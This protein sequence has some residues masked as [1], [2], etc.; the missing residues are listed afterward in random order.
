MAALGY[1]PTDPEYIAMGLYFGQNAPPVT[2]PQYGWVGCQD[3]TAIAAITVDS[4]SAGT[5]WKLNDTFLILQS[6]ASFG[7]GQ[8]TG[9]SGTTVTSV[10][11]I[12][13]QQGTGYS[14]ANALSTTAQA[15][16]TGTGLEVNITA[17]GE[18]V[19][20]AIT[21]CRLAN[22]SW[23]GAMWCNGA[24]SDVAPIAAYEQTV[25]PAM[26]YI[27]AT[28]SLSALQGT[29]GNVF[30][31]IKAL[32]YGRVQGIYTST[33]NVP[34]PPAPAN[35]YAAAAILGVAMGLNTGAPNSAFT[36]AAKT[37]VGIQT[38]V[39]T[40]AQINV[41]AGTPG[42]GFGNNGNSYNNYANDYDFYY[43]GVNGNG[44]S[45]TTVQ[46]LD[47]LAADAQ[48]SVL[49][50]LQSLP[51]IPQNDAGQALILNA[52]RGACSRA[53]TRGFV[54][55]GVWEGATLLPLTSQSLTPGT[56]L[57][58]GYWV[59]SPSFL[60]QSSGD[61]ALFKSMPVYVAVVLAG[62][63][64]SFVIGIFVQQ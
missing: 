51:S 24:D 12:P 47:M 38:T 53:G 15:P 28:E 37:L 57:P 18:T 50:V 22:T 9:V 26:Q 27:Y 60:T 56:A 14:V 5:G 59:G 48:L 40:Q 52:V 20:Q 39:L 36:V 1:Q 16:S 58:T 11:F 43:Q 49:N 35:V 42:L 10:A 23:Y 34:V 32:N 61:R 3:P 64:Q 46:G 63:Q 31:A 19:L 44:L 7:Y 33:S 45:F 13:G 21:A 62:T 55:P 17:V 29:T 54:A 8:V 2:P 30:S 41:F 6:N 4:S 25:Q